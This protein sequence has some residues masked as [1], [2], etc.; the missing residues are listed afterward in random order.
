MKTKKSRNRSSTPINIQ[1]DKTMYRLDAHLSW[2]SSLKISAVF[3]RSRENHVSPILSQIDGQTDKQT[4][5]RTD[6]RTDGRTFR[7]IE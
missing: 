5:G 7:M 6:R 1:M 2:E 4:D 3:N